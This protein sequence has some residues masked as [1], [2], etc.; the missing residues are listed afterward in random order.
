M[1]NTN[2]SKKKREFVGSVKNDNNRTLIIGFS[3][4]G[5]NYLMNHILLQKQEPIFISKKSLN[6]YPKIKAQT[7]DEIQPLEHYENSTVVLMICYC[8]NKKAILICFLLE[9]AT[10]ILMFIKF[11]KAIFI[12]QK[13]PFAK[14]Y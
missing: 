10:K 13:I 5:K 4:C 7:S 8:Q 3:N 1:N 11:L 9:D 6:Q 14:F 2:F 12:S